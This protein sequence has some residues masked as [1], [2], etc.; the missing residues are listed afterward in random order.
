M[1]CT[2]NWFDVLITL[3]MPERKAQNDSK[4][5]LQKEIKNSYN[6]FDA[7]RKN[8]ALLSGQE[9]CVMKQIVMYV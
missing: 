9:N 6:S 5:S 8:I 7:S 3:M 2:N 4:Q 1:V